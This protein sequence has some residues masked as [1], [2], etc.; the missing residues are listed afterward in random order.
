[1]TAPATPA[2]RATIASPPVPLKSDFVLLGQPLTEIPTKSPGALKRS[3]AFSWVH[4][5]AVVVMAMAVAI[6]IGVTM[7]RVIA[8]TTTRDRVACKTARDTADHCAYD[9]VRSQAPNQRAASRAQR[10]SGIMGMT[11]ATIGRGADGASAKRKGTAS[12][13]P[14]KAFHLILL[15]FP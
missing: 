2:N 12:R 13:N 7:P 1:M 10:G 15:G 3:G 14:G 8:I 6:Q 11:A 9:T 5:L 4:V